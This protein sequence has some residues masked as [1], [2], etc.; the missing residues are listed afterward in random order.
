VS[1]HRYSYYCVCVCVCVPTFNNDFSMTIFDTSV[2]NE[3]SLGGRIYRKEMR[4]ILHNPTNRAFIKGV[5]LLLILKPLLLYM[6]G[7][8]ND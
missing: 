8:Y 5:T 2:L 4:N 7:V 3:R 1:A 6:S